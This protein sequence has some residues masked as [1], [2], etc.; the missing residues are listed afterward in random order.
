MALQIEWSPPPGSS[1]PSL[2]HPSVTDAV[3]V[4][5]RSRFSPYRCLLGPWLF[6]PEQL[7]ITSS[8]KPSWNAQIKLSPALMV[9]LAWLLPTR[10]V[11]VFIF[12]SL[13]RL[14]TL[15]ATKSLSICLLGFFWALHLSLSIW[16]VKFSVS[17]SLSPS[18]GP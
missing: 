14:A 8:R 13:T 6:Q 4:S 12:S 2:P 17:L 10:I 11:T 9:P 3:T 7:A 5:L 16:S 18:L 15:W 1:P